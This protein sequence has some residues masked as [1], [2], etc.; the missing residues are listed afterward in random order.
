MFPTR[1]MFYFFPSDYMDNMKNHFLRDV[2]G[3]TLIKTVV[4]K[5]MKKKFYMNIK[6]KYATVLNK[7]QLNHKGLN[8]CNL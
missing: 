7:L 1:N 8:I 6:L 4:Q 3:E 2:K 5:R